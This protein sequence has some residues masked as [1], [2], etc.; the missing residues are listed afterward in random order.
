MTVSNP[1]ETRSPVCPAEV[2]AVTGASSITSKEE[3]IAYNVFLCHCSY[4]K[5][6]LKKKK[7]TSVNLNLSKF[8]FQR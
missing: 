2:A 4:M 7:E 8:K 1:V 3:V 6:Q 5:D